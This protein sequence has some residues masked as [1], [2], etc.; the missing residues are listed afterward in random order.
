MKKLLVL[1]T[2][3]VT[4]SSGLFGRSL[5]NVMAE[6]PQQPTMY[7]YYKSIQIQEGDSLWSIAR[8]YCFNVDI[9]SA[10]YVKELKKMNG[11]KQ[12]TIH[13]GQKLTVVYFSEELQN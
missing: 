5:L 10:E 9:S 2:L 12:D 4:I 6:E 7:R 11:L 3:C 13:A 8:E 1:F